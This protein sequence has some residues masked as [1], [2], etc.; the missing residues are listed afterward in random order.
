MNNPLLLNTAWWLST[1]LSAQRFRRALNQPEAA[2]GALLKRYL[3]NNINTLFG[4]RH[5]FAS[6]S[7]MKEFQNRVPLTT[8]G[9][10]ES[11]I[12]LIL[13]DKPNILTQDTVLRMEP[14][15]AAARS[16]RLIPYT[17]TL[18][19]EFQR[20]LHPWI[21]DLFTQFPALFEGNA[22][23]SF[24]PFN[25]NVAPRA[26]KIPIG[27]PDDPH[28]DCNYLGWI[29]HWLTNSIFCV[30]PEVRHITDIE[31]FR[32]VT[33]AF[34]LKCRSLRF[35][36]VWHPSFL[37]L[38]TTML[39]QHWD[40]LLR[41]IERG[42]LNPPGGIAP[43]H[44]YPL[45]PL[46]KEDFGR[47]LAL[48]QCSPHAPATIWPD[49]ELISCWGEGAAEV[50]KDSLQQYFPR[51]RI[52][53]KGLI[54]TEAFMT[55]P[56]SGFKPLAIRSH[57]FE[58]M[59]EAGKMHLSHEVRLE[60]EYQLVVTTGGGLYRYQMGDQVKVT[61]FIGQTPSLAF[62]GKCEPPADLSGDKLDTKTVHT[63]L[64]TLFF[65]H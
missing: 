23:W 62:L 57:F 64:N 32:Y 40:S 4:K 49:L 30:P 58:F 45:R 29:G 20:A 13:K 41:D 2:Q 46:F 50:H 26:S 18:K 60:H 59:D 43:A 6:I 9:Y 36:S 51:T 11:A 39:P 22:Y 16:A 7:T 21:W 33:L 1:Q 48:K 56:F 52:Q 8:Y 24:P 28:D 35:I 63:V 61:G 47:A 53:D 37:T 34:L 19:R 12:D 44:A 17:E 38:M 5:G 31:T 15:S 65:Q 55:V 25:P 14:T 10:Y 54:A 27:S 42:S 3:K